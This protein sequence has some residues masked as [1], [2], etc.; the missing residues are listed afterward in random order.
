MKDGMVE[1]D[2]SKFSVNEKRNDSNGSKSASGLSAGNGTSDPEKGGATVGSISS[3]VG[4]EKRGERRILWGHQ[5]KEEGDGGDESENMD[6]LS[7]EEEESGE[8]D[9]WVPVSGTS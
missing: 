3:D 5:R 4:K 2:E 7:P 1:D 9:R 6:N 8:C